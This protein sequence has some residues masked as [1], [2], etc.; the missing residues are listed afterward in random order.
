MTYRDRIE[1]K[2]TA[3]LAPLRLEI[4]DQSHK[5]AGHADRIA[6]LG[7]GG[8]APVDGGGE[9]HFAI[10]VVSTAFA[11]QSRVERQ[12]LVYD[13]LKNE[14]AERVHAL[15]LKTQTPEEAGLA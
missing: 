2:L 12:R 4:E 11:G 8:H 1:T 5:H 13:L 3:A 6:A 14:L 10:R 9:T 15:A 7:G